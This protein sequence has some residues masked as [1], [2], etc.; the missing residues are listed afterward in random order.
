[1]ISNKAH[2]GTSENHTKVEMAVCSSNIETF[3]N[4]VVQKKQPMTTILYGI[5]IEGIINKI[6]ELSI[7]L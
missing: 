1:M 3:V 2:T 6:D 7:K 5:K 4:S